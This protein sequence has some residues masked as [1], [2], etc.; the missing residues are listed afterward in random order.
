MSVRFITPLYVKVILPSRWFELRGLWFRHA[1]PIRKS[2][3]LKR[4]TQYLCKSHLTDHQDS[5]INAFTVTQGTSMNNKRKDKTDSLKKHRTL[6]RNA[7]RISDSLFLS[8][9]FFDPM[10]L[11]QVRYEMLRR[12]KVD[13]SSISDSAH[14]F[15]VS[16]PTWYQSEKDFKENGL[17][18]LVPQR[19]GPRRAHKLDGKVL[20]AV[21]KAR[22]ENPAA[23]AV[24]L[25]EMVH[26]KFGISVH[27]RSIERALARVKKK[28]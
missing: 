27:R 5:G 22:H 21:L 11:L 19:A 16:R 8:D 9:S 24:E 15:G 17:A 4:L 13:G 7:N 14:N 25:A 3:L 20:E 10:D 18:G 2:V 23:S 6:N 26:K 1:T 12:V 28:P